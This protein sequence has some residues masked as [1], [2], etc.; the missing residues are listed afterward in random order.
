VLLLQ[1]IWPV[2]VLKA[3]L[4][5]A[6]AAALLLAQYIG[7]SGPVIVIEDWQLC[8]RLYLQHN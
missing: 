6:T 2:W 5:A 1:V 4:A 3:A 7:Q 8:Y